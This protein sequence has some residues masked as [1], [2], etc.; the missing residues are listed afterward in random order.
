MR[1]T[2]KAEKNA[3]G[4][5]FSVGQVIFASLF[6]AS[7]VFLALFGGVFL[8]FGRPDIVE[9]DSPALAL[10]DASS[11]MYIVDSSR[12]RLIR[13][14]ASGGVDLIVKA[15]QNSFSEIYDLTVDASGGI[16][17]LDTVRDPRN[18]RIKSETVQRYSS[19]GRFAEEIFRAD[20]EIPTFSR[21]I[22]GFAPNGNS[23]C[24]FVTL[25]DDRVV[26]R[27]ISPDKPET[28]NETSYAFPMAS[29]IFN[30]FDVGEGGLILFTT[31]RG[32]IYKTAGR[33]AERIFSSRAQADGGDGAIPWDVS[34][35]DDGRFY[36]T[37][38]ARR[39]VYSIDAEG[40][41]EIVYSDPDTIYYR[42]SAKNGLVAVS[43]N[44]VITLSDGEKATLEKFGVTVVILA[45]RLCSWLSMA[46]L[47]TGLVWGSISFARFLLRKDSF[48]VKF[49]AGVITGTLFITVVFCLIVTKDITNRMTREMLNRLTNVAELVALQ[50]PVESFSSLDSIDDYMNED[51]AAVESLIDNIMVSRG[52][53]A[54]MYCVLYRILDGAIAEVF[55]SDNNH[56]IVN[57]PYDWPL[58]GSDEMEILE[59]GN[60]KTYTYPSWVDGGV[61]FS[62]CPVYGKTGEA[63]G[64][65]EIGSDLAAFKEENKNLVFNLFLNVVSMSIAMIIVAVEFLVF[66]DGRRK[67]K[68]LAA[69]GSSYIPVDMMRS[70]VFLVYFMTNMST[71][72]LP[73]YAR[74][75]VLTEGKT[76]PF[77][78]EFL[79]AAP[80]SADVLMGAI[81]SLLGT[82][83]VKKLG[84][85][86]TAIGGGIISLAGICLECGARDIFTLTAGFGLCGFGCGLALFLTNL[87][88]AGE[89]D[90]AEKERGFAGITVAMTSGING[91]VVFGA[92]LTNWLSHRSVLATAALVSMALL[93]F[94]VRYM[95][96]LDLPSL[97]R[98]KK[99]GEMSTSRFLFSPR[100]FLYMLTLLGPAIASGYFLIYL[101]PIVGFDFGISE[102]NIGYSFLL[103]SLVVIVFSSSLTNVFSRKFGKPVSLSLWALIYAGAFAAFAVFQ[104]VETLLIALVLMGFADSFGQSLSTSYYTE[105]PDVEKYGYGRAIGISSVIDNAAQTIGP[106]VFSYA[107]HIGL[108]EGLLQIAG[109]LVALSLVF[110]MTSIKLRKNRAGK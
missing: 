27:S 71:G 62:L 6:F 78:M 105:L 46:I 60:Y 95:A 80:I 90:G 72:F 23:G 100:V 97:S 49:S 16:F 66:L 110:L 17:I 28:P 69:R 38:L 82:W 70:G 20:H 107:L 61:I 51:Y 1:F 109:G 55:D 8:H 45:M 43:E 14:D 35:G 79:I 10:R 68:E 52:D 88:I 74:N 87:K 94:S 93:A 56:G 12:K 76:L 48:V 5:G 104:N 65:I 33:E 2:Y 81:A 101:F 98:D 75:M 103:N 25:E 26:L 86:R 84:L 91:G 96:K 40:K 67:M 102:S 19:N 4:S 22:A 108:R 73:L 30:H 29:K 32:E 18:R 39:G 85:R 36:F 64:L 106:F 7:I 57:Y 53:Y 31:R 50:I 9:I 44:G 63:V 54:G 41:S 83:I 11:N 59:T 47:L 42:V 24:S 99:S 34:A 13:A 77:P 89:G 37:D 92:F 3:D 58:E 15:G 21:T